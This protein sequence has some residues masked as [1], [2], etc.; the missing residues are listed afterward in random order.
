MLISQ[1]AFQNWVKRCHL[2][3]KQDIADYTEKLCFV[4]EIH[5]VQDLILI[6]VS[7]SK[8]VRN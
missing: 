2:C 6:Y 1:K 7:L 8:E 3:F 4:V 5:I